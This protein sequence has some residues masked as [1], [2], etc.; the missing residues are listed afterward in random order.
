MITQQEAA[1]VEHAIGLLGQV[2]KIILE[3]RCRHRTG[4]PSN[5]RLSSMR[6]AV[7]RLIRGM[8]ELGNL[9]SP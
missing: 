9:P 7:L 4:G 5:K 1:Q 8:E 6:H 2:E 3:L